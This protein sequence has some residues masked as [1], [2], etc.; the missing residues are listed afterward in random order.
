MK[1]NVLW[2]VAGL[3]DAVRE[4]KK[5]LERVVR[6]CQPIAV[7]YS[8]G[9]D[10]T[11]LLISAA[12]VLGCENVGAFTV[13]S[14]LMPAAELRRARQIVRQYGIPHHCLSFPILDNK[15]F[16]ANPRDRC[17][18]CKKEMFRLL[19]SAARAKGYSCVCDGTNRDDTREFRPGSK[20]AQEEKIIRP[21]MESGFTKKNVRTLSRKMGLP[22]WNIPSQTCLATR[23]PYG[24]GISREEVKRLDTAEEYLRRRGFSRVRLRR[25]REG[26]RA[27]LA[28]G[29]I[30]K[31]T[32]LP[33]RKKI[34]A[35]LKR[36]GYRFITVDLAGYR[37][38][39]MDTASQAASIM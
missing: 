29:D 2:E 14:P 10:S 21:L 34:V 25:I 30:P 32:R 7:A 4:K 17:Y 33:L 16:T 5:R 8:G 19:V 39:S 9:A 24:M 36:K 26:I 3:S 15:T 12:R 20:A 6:G 27:E 37:S 18:I 38:G 28:P 11:F 13:T 1:V 23:F 35:Y 31:I 22:T